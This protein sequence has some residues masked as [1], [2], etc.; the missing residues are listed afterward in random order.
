MGRTNDGEIEKAVHHALIR[1]VG[2]PDRSITVAVAD[3]HVTLEGSVAMPEERDSIERIVASVPS[4]RG[5]TNRI[6]IWPSDLSSD[7]V[8]ET[9]AESLFRV[10]PTPPEK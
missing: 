5:V 6:G 9:I 3:G 1:C 7:L 10:A 8:R 2:V 4:V